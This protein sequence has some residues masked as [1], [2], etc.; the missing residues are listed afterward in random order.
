MKKTIF[1]VILLGALLRVVLL[2]QSFWLDES[3][4]ALVVKSQSFIQIL[5]E[6]VKHDNHPPLY[7]LTL[8]LWSDIFGYSEVA[9]RSLSVLF[10]LGTIYLVFKIGE[11]FSKKTG[12]LAA[13]FI[14][15]SQFHIYY[16][17]EA[18]MYSMAAFLAA[19]AFYLFLK[20]KWPYFALVITLLIFTDYVPVFLL[21]VFVLIGIADEK[22]AKWWKRLFLCH[23]PLLI[24]GLI[25]APILLVQMQG[26]RWLLET[27]PAWSRLAGGATPKQV[28][29]VW[30]KF[31]FGR[32]SLYNK[33]LY[34][35]LTGLFSI[36]FL[37]TFLRSWQD[38]KKT[39]LL[40][41]Y[42]A[43]PLFIGFITSFI[44]PNLIYFR[45]LYILP[46]FYLLAAYGIGKFR[47]KSLFLLIA[48]IL[49][50][51]A[52]SFLIYIKEPYLHREAWRESVKFVESRIKNDEIVAFNFTEPF[53]PY[54]WYSNN[55]V[56]ALGL[57]DSIAANFEPTRTKMAKVLVGVN[58]I[59]YFEY[60]W[61]LHDPTRIVASTLNSNGFIEV[62]AFDFPG[63]GAVRYLRRL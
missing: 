2:N 24:L 39:Y 51:N 22:P 60:L 62:A 56:P 12:L 41:L 14:A 26:G 9:L 35:T 45:F 4:G 25:W 5:T 63:V 27:L 37:I 40:W 38:R 10:G 3:I 47:G 16:S 20:E 18:R 55:K 44:F 30:M 19:L 49:S 31:V 17:Q 28:A 42:L 11:T 58:G 59:Y 52:L 23:L 50:G 61:E 15:T 53:A 8:K 1:L 54:Q 6:F 13:L 57:T 34:Y 36:P 7:Y 43:V 29:L 48:L 32:I 46:A 21:P 33:A